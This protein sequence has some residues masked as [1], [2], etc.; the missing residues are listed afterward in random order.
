MQEGR[1]SSDYP[2]IQTKIPV[3]SHFQAPKIVLAR[4]IMKSDLICFGPDTPVLD[5]VEVLLKKNITG[6]PVVDAG[7]YLLGVI[8]E[9][10]VLKLVMNEGYTQTPSGTVSEYMSKDVESVGPE[11]EVY[12]IASLFYQRSYRRLPVV[13]DNKVLGIISRRDILSFI[14]ELKS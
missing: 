7:G 4:E 8:S 14:K 10:D 12:K 9:K 5:C 11:E 2:T 13:K 1:Y 3:D 6:A